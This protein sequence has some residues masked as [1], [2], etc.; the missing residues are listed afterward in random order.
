[1][2]FGWGELVKKSQ[3][4]FH[5]AAVWGAPIGGFTSFAMIDIDGHIAAGV[6]LLAP[7]VAT[8]AIYKDLEI[9]HGGLGLNWKFSEAYGL[10]MFWSSQSVEL[11]R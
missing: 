1:M 11:C 10:L 8:A 9:F 3:I 6:K 2:G 4:I 7:V 5:Q